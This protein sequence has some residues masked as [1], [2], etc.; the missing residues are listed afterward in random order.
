[1]MA[2]LRGASLVVPDGMP[3]VW[4][5]NMLGES[6][7]DRVYGP[8]LMRRYSERCAERGHRVWLYGGR[9]QGT[10][11]QLALSL[12][13]NHPDIQIV[14]GYSPPFRPLGEQEENTI[15]DQI[16]D[17]KPDVLWVGIGVPKQEKWMAHMR[18]RLDVPVMCGVGAAFDFH[19][20]PH[21]DGAPLDAGPRARVGLPDL[22]G[23]GPSAPALPLLQPAL[24]ALVRAPVPRRALGAPRWPLTRPSGRGRRRCVR[25]S[26][27]SAAGTR[28]RWPGRIRPCRPRRRRATGSIAST[29][30]STRSC[31]DAWRAS[32]APPFA[33]PRPA[34][35]RR[36]TGARSHSGFAAAARSPRASPSRARSR[37]TSC[38]PRRSATSSMTGSPRR[39]WPPSRSGSSRRSASC[40]KRPAPATAGASRSRTRCITA[41]SRRCAAPGSR[42]TCRG[43][44]CRRWR[45]ARSRRGAPITTPT[46]WRTRSAP[47]GMP[48]SRRHRPRLR[49]F[50]GRWCAC[51][52]P[53]IRRST[54]TAAIRCPTPSPAQAH[55]PGISFEQSPERPPL[56]HPDGSFD[57]V[58]AISIWSHFSEQAALRWLD[59]MRRAIRP[60]GAWCSPRR[61]ST[62]WPTPTAW[63]ALA[64]AARRDSRGAQGEWVLVRAGVRRGGRPRAGQ[65]G[66]GN[67]LP[68]SGVAAGQGHARLARGAI[69]SRRVE[70]NQDLYV[71]ERR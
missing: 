68:H 27:S 13:R 34:S 18:D 39:T 62:P 7:D 10:L 53:R 29:W 71:L 3:L 46:W 21:P 52:P 49:L 22:P 11:V 17:A 44:T 26:T 31:A 55:L 60:Q 24:R 9:D 40:V 43:T 67:R 57:F 35:T 36:D 1:M 32:S 51:W 65:P 37:P 23:A 8:E 33:E 66:M 64:G 19:A 4:A 12:R 48:W 56:H 58:F 42:P 50:L 2:A 5:S 15:V 16:N 45:A 59:A 63:T 20:G 61:G 69:L 41:S 54:G 28:R 47:P 38:T 6:L 14:G 70:G 25:S 30:I